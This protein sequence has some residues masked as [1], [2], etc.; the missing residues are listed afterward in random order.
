M[1]YKDKN[2]AAEYRKKYQQENRE[3]LKEYGRKYYSENG[4]K[5]QDAEERKR[6]LKKYRE[7]NKE[8]L[9]EKQKDYCE[10][11]KESRREQQAEYREL[12]R[13]K[14]NAKSREWY[15]KNKEKRN[16]YSKQYQK[17]NKEELNRKK[18]EKYSKDV[19]YRLKLNLRN[20]LNAAIRNKC[21]SGS[22][23]KDLGCTI[24]DFI[25]YIESLFCDGM[26]WE[27]WGEWHLDHI[28]PLSKFDLE[29]REQ[30]L[31]ACNYRNIQP[32]WALDNLQKS[33]KIQG[34]ME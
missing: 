26:T 3:K 4:R 13:E 16:K 11:N 21:K 17:D 18:K 32:M 31:E 30:F 14:R 27:N 19:S 12:N 23:V 15:Y 28:K 24:D 10:K 1:P 8:I 7:E 9:A 20:R 33:N 6:Y 34:K 2:K 25:L 22:A 29:N 5:P